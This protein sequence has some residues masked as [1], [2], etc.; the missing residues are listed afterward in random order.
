[1]IWIYLLTRVIFFE[2]PATSSSFDLMS[3]SLIWNVGF[4]INSLFYSSF[5]SKLS[6]NYSNSSN[7]F[8]IYCS[9]FMFLYL[10]VSSVS[11]KVNPNLLFFSITHVQYSHCN[12]YFLVLN[13]SSAM[14]I[15]LWRRH[16]IFSRRGRISNSSWD[17]MWTSGS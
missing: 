14:L 8:S 5:V 10:V 7:A 4:R 17:L 9:I 13:N 1:M 12:T 6:I 2:I 3:W 11:L 15:H 16:V